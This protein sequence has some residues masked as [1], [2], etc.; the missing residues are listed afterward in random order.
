MSLRSNCLTKIHCLNNHSY[1]FA[2]VGHDENFTTVW[3]GILVL[4]WI[5]PVSSDRCM[6]N[7]IRKE[8]IN[9]MPKTSLIWG[10]AIFHND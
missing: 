4:V 6:A 10:S 9:L 3:R 2:L 7:H 1:N 5:I 8:D